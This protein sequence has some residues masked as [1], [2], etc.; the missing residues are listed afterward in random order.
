MAHYRFGEQ[1]VSS[2][3]VG[4][5]KLLESFYG[6]QEAERPVCLCKEPGGPMYIACVAGKHILKRMPNTGS[7]HTLDCDSYEPLDMYS[8]QGDLEG[9]AINHNQDGTVSL[10][11]DF[12]LTLRSG[13]TPPAASA[14]EGSS[15]KKRTKGLT[16]RGYLDCL[17]VEAELNRWHPGMYGKRGWRV[18]HRLLTNAAVV[19]Q[20][21]GNPLS[22][23][24]YVPE[25]YKPNDKDAIEARLLARIRPFSQSPRNAR[26]LMIVIGEYKEFRPAARG[27]MLILRH[28][29]HYPFLIEEQIYSKLKEKYKWALDLL[30]MTS[31][32]NNAGHLMIAATVSISE[33]QIASVEEIALQ[34]Y[35]EHW[36]PIDN[37]FELKMASLLVERNRSFL[38]FLRLNRDRREPMP[39]FQLLDTEEPFNIYIDNDSREE[40]QRELLRWLNGEKSQY[41]VWRTDSGVFPTLPP[42][43][44]QHARQ[45]LSETAEQAKHRSIIDARKFEKETP[46]E[47]SQPEEPAVVVN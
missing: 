29:P 26:K 28:V 10:K 27:Q 47:E 19:Q 14:S 40:Y 38:K 2:D 11:F 45:P 17:W 21:K 16:L 25:P 35:D 30:D 31:Q 7:L 24:L 1:I 6:I 32:N 39:L 42:K 41:G 44:S 22:E 43:R 37:V 15:I 34:F 20:T 5:E 9:T 33:V 18:V 46:V 8:G 3:Q 4:F 12:P 23:V 13:K 36:L